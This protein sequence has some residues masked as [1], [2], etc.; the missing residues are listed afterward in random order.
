MPM[1]STNMTELSHNTEFVRASCPP[2]SG[3]VPA[4]TEARVGDA[5]VQTSDGRE[6]HRLLGVGRD[7]TTWIK[8]R[9]SQ[10]GFVE[11]V[12]FVIVD[13]APQIGG[14]GNRGA[15]TDYYLTL[16]M[17]KELAM[18]ENNAEGRRIRR[19]FIECERRVLE[20][21]NTPAPDLNDPH[22]LRALLLVHAEREIAMQARITAAEGT[23]AVAAP[24]ADALDRIAETDGSLNLRE[25][26]KTLQV[27]PMD[28]NEYLLRT[29]W[30]FRAP[31]SD[32][33]V[34]RQDRINAGLLEHKTVEIA[35]GRTVSQVFVTPRGLTRLAQAF[36]AA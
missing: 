15:R 17:A 1:E 35:E 29:G 30:L 22:A 32:R 21:A 25:T 20:A 4:V 27:R 19:Y 7:F 36:S 14:V 11:S 28:L 9:I 24:K 23:L 6:L 13:T 31:K 34:A 12:D 10:Y 16:G 18:M 3:S 26:A 5:L 8:G 2:M 33:L